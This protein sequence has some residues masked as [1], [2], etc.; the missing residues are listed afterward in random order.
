MA[1]DR[2]AL[3]DFLAKNSVGDDMWIMDPLEAFFKITETGQ[4]PLL[5]EEEIN[6]AVLKE[7]ISLATDRRV[8][9]V[10]FISLSQPFVK[11][12]W[13]SQIVYNCSFRASLG[14]ELGQSFYKNIWWSSSWNRFRNVF[15]ASLWKNL[16]DI[17]Q[18]SIKN[19]FWNGLRSSFKETL[20]TNI[21]QM[22]FSYL[23][24]Y[25]LNEQERVEELKPLIEFCSKCWILG[26]K[27]DEPETLLVICK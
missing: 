4:Y 23:G 24:Y 13:M 1:V 9:K 11:P 7:A 18:D 3:A 22:L 8:T 20:T 27:D 16:R 25:L 10:T 17:L 21:Y 5:S 15:N 19:S 26:F 12:D 14:T 6:L 2:Q